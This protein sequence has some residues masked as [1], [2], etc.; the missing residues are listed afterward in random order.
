[1]YMCFV[2]ESGTPRKPDGQGT[3]YFVFGG[4]VIPE[5][6]WR[7]VL[8]RLR[9]LKTNNGYRGEVKWR[10]FAPKNDDSRNP[11]RE[12]SPSQRNDFREAFFR[13]L[14]AEDSVRIIA[15]VC[16]SNIAY[17][18]LSTVNSQEDIYFHTY[19]V[20]TERFQYFLQDVSK[21]RNQRASGIIVADHRN[22]PQDHRMREQHERLVR[23]TRQ[24]TTNYKH[25]VESIFLAPSHMSVGIQFADMVAGAIWRFHEYDDGRWIDHIRGSFRTNPNGAVIDGYGLA[26]F[27]KQGWTGP[28]VR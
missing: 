4:V 27:P 15:G 26:R 14:R 3:R 20:V 18:Q 10:Y 21:L 22:D 8:G 2:D 17:S 5:E 12:W 19:K 25:F 13:I 9:G 24:Y 23:E 11:M 6:R 7:M 28:I 1:M 16:D